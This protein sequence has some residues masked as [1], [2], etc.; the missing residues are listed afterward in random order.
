METF[1][2]ILVFGILGILVLNLLTGDVNGTVGTAVIGSIIFVIY[3]A[4]DY[5]IKRIK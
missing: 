4:L 5:V 1:K 3:Y 2:F